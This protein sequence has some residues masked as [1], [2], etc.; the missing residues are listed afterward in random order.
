MIVTVSSSRTLRRSLVLGAALAAFYAVP[1]QAQ[2]RQATVQ[3]AAQPLGTALE[4]LARQTGTDILFAPQLVAGM[5]GPSLSGRMDAMVAVERLIQGKPL[6]VRRQG[7]GALLI[8]AAAAE[9]QE[10]VAS[11]GGEVA[12]DI[13]VTGY[14]ASLSGALAEKRK[15]TNVVDVVKAEDIGK[16][17]AQNIAEALQRVPGV[18]IVRDRGEGVFVRIRGLGANFQVVTLNGR[19]AAVN[20]NVRD[21][22]QSGRQFRFDTLPSELMSAVEVIKSPRADLAEGGIGGI[23]NLQTFRPIDLKK[24]V[25][26]LSATA[27]SPRL[28]D[29]VDP[30]L[31]G[32]ASWVNEEGTFGALIAAVYDERT[33]R[34]DR[35]TGVGWADGRIDADGD[36]TLD[37]D[38]ILVPTSTRPTLER[39]NRNRIGLNGAIQWKPDDRFELNV[40]GLWS[41]LNIDYD[42]L[43]Y[44]TDFSATTPGAIVPGTAVIENGVL[45]AATVTTSTQIGR[46]TSRLEY[47]NWLIGANAKWSAN[48]WTLAADASLGRAYSNTPTPIYRTRLLGS[49]GQVAFDYGKVGERLPNLEFLT[50]DLTQST[51]LPGRRIE[52]RVNDSLDRQRAATFDVTRELSGVVQ[53]LRFGAKY[54][55]R[56]RTYNR[57]DINFTSGI[58]GQRFDDSYF[59]AFPVDDFLSGVGGN[60]PTNWVMPDPD[61]FWDAATGKEALLDAP[62]TRGDR[63]NSYAIDERII[64]GYGMAEFSL[65]LGGMTI[66][67]DAG[68]RYAHTRQT[69]SGYADNGSAA[70]PVSYE[71]NYG[72][73]LP[74]LNLVA[75]FT[76]NLQMHLAAS[77]VITRPSL[78][79]L[80]PRLTINSNPTVLTA[81]GGNP[82]LRP[83]EAWQYDGTVEWYFAP[84]SAL[85][86]GAFYKDITTFVFQQTRNFDLDGQ[87]Y[88]LT[89]P[90]NGGNAYVAGIEIAYQ[91]LFKMLPAPF[92]GLGF[93]ANYT[94]TKSKGTYALSD[95][96]TFRD[97]LT[98]VAGDSFN[99][100][101]F[102]EKGPV[103]A[104]ASYS[105]RGK[106]LRD[107]G[108]A[109][110][111]ANNDAAFGSLDFDISYKVTPNV[112]FVVQGINVTGGVQW[113]YVRDDRFAGYT[114]YGTTLMAGVRARF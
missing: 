100:T 3:I 101:A 9:P 74:S 54:E 63:R 80:A 26:A 93:Q 39:E 88:R 7:N 110:L 29:T 92:D 96:T 52:Y 51:T 47:E 57:R 95:G 113:Q 60:L 103:G 2:Q 25:L 53:A 37:S 22:G 40:D 107:V 20:E 45:T 97:D 6:A 102:Y 77:K 55:K 67:G 8:V 32:M 19:S 65:P 90:Q 46:E 71:R 15:A 76:S 49:V 41:R 79:D 73:F 68:L 109:G 81:V 31:S 42:E 43:T 23:V 108:G 106:V 70:L 114:D 69:S 85:I 44:S 82:E 61:R 34:Q 87:I 98:D 84:G 11:G 18:S 58:S 112:T 59:E 38:T 62:L 24:P 86:G 27:S 94:H 36:G 105:W 64:G 83:F 78:A 104:R 12:P 111:A 14:A 21:S 91:Q 4:A 1:A 35:V 10:T 17:P 30:R 66:R 75:E 72:N 5:S 48:G 28:A 56:D 33:T 99:L 16:F 89:A 50:A 13:I